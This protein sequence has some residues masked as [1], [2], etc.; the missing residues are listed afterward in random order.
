MVDKVFILFYKINSIHC[1]WYKEINSWIC[2]SILRPYS[3]VVSSHV[4]IAQINRV[5]VKKGE[6]LN[7]NERKRKMMRES[8]M[9][10]EEERRGTWPKRGGRSNYHDGQTTKKNKQ[11]K[12]TKWIE[13]GDRVIESKSN[14]SCVLLHPYFYFVINRIEDI[15]WEYNF[16]L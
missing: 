1:R 9:V 10:E 11:N 4:K 14:L 8:K 6:K 15:S 13:R 2:I 12:P 3:N 7:V 16:Y 5:N